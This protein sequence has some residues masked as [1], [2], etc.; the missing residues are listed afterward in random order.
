MISSEKRNVTCYTDFWC[1]S[2][3][4][5]LFYYFPMTFI[6]VSRHNND[7]SIINFWKLKKKK[8]TFYYTKKHYPN[9]LDTTQKLLTRCLKR[10]QCACRVYNIS[11]KFFR[12]L[13]LIPP[14]PPATY[15]DDVTWSSD[16][17]HRV[18]R[19][20]RILGYSLVL[21]SQSFRSPLPPSFPPTTPVGHFRFGIDGT[22][23][24]GGRR[25]RPAINPKDAR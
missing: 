24:P 23:S 11:D 19:P 16:I 14:P 21:V 15:A 22:P 18:A 20:N 13:M 5:H 10:W 12:L 7:Y 9:T 8:E 17:T 1:S 3:C 4:F 6:K 2:D 25:R